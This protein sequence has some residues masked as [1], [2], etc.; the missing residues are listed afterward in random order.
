MQVYWLF[1]AFYNCI[2]Y[3]EIERKSKYENEK[4]LSELKPF[5]ETFQLNLDDN[6]QIDYFITFKNEGEIPLEILNQ[7]GRWR[8]YGEK[9]VRGWFS[10]S[11]ER[12]QLFLI[13]NLHLE[14]NEFEVTNA[15]HG[16]FRL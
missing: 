14:E 11:K 2:W 8:H 7:M 15:N 9:K 12:I 1:F 4:N 6:T 16:L 10:L 3:T 5:F 13:E